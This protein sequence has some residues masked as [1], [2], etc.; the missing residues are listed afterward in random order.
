MLRID[1]VS[2]TTSSL[3]AVGDWNISAFMARLSIPERQKSDHD[4]SMVMTGP[5]TRSKSK[6]RSQPLK[7]IQAFFINFYIF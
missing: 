4:P 5:R 7:G 6:K 3:V 1:V 2:V